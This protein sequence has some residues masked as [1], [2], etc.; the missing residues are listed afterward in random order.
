MSDIA[1]VRVT[2]GD[3][4]EA[5]RIGHLMIEERLAACVNVDAPCISTFRWHDRVEM[6]EEVTATFKTTVALAHRLAER[7]AELH[8]YDAPVI[9][10]WPVAVSEAVATWVR[11]GTVS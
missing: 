3:P 9:E 6:A 8:S 2:F 7:V 1:L 10:T 11:G 4:D 5:G